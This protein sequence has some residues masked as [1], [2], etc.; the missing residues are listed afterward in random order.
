MSTGN[1]GSRPCRLLRGRELLRYPDPHMRFRAKFR[2]L[3]WGCVALGLLY[4]FRMIFGPH[5]LAFGWWGMV[6]PIFAL[7][8]VLLNRFVYWEIKTDGLRERR[9][10][11]VREVPW[12]EVTHVRPWR[13]N[14]P[15][16]AYLAI[17]FA[18][19]APMSDRGTVI[20]NPEARSQFIGALRKFAPKAEFE[21]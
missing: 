6:W 12:Q 7:E 9:L 3:D 4:L 20:A 11:S 5:T 1:C 2:L 8:F 16:S 18:R 13:E 21:V 10:W 19:S 15:S 17:D 14:K